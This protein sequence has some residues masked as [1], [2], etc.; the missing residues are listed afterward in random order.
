MIKILNNL[1]QECQGWCTL[2][3]SIYIYNLILDNNLKKGLEIG[4]YNGRSLFAAAYAFKEN[5]GHITGIDPW[6]FEEAFQPELPE[7]NKFLEQLNIER[8]YEDTLS[9]AIKY[10]LNVTVIRTTSDK[11][12]E[13]NTEIFDYIHVDGNHSSDKAYLDIQNALKILSPNG[14]LLLDDFL[15]ETLKPAYELLLS[16]MKQ[17]GEIEGTAIFSFY[18]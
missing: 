12:F 1:I 5:K 9:K 8:F 14:F 2:Q 6:T 17:I 16:K 18:C 7:A 4:V 10:D 15:W 3:K 11:F 13:K